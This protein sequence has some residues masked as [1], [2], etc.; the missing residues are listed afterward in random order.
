MKIS[1]L[2][3][4]LL[5]LAYGG[6]ATLAQEAAPPA[7]P[8][9]AA[10]APVPAP[11][12]V[13]IK[14]S[15]VGVIGK[16]DIRLTGPD[17]RQQIV[18]MASQGEGT[19]WDATREA[20]Y[21][22]VPTGVAAVDSH[23]FLSPVANGSTTLTAKVGAF[24]A[25]IPIVVEKF[26]ASQ[27]VS[28]HNEVIPV[29]TRNG[30]NSGGCHGKSGGQNGFRL[31][32]FG[33]E[34]WKDYDWLVHED[35]GRR[36]FP[37]APEHSLLLTKASGEV[38]HQ[39]GARLAIGGGDYG[40]LARWIRQGSP[41]GD[42]EKPK[43]ERIE[44]YPRE[45][46]SKAHASQQLVVTA[47]FNDGSSRDITH[48]AQFEANQK[49]MAESS[50]EG[51]VQLK[52]LTGTTSVMVKFKEHVDVF[53]ATI[54]LGAGTPQLPLAKNQVDEQVFAKLKLLGL[55]PSPV[56][57]DATFLRRVTV[58]ITG[59]LP[60]REESEAFLSLNT[61]D[62]RAKVVDALLDSDDYADYFGQKWTN[63]LRN[64]RSKDEYARG[65]F[66]FHE[67]VR[68]SMKENKPYNQFVS[69]I[70]TA[71]GEIGRNP[72]VAWYRSVSDQKEQMQD[73]AQVFLGIRM[74]CAQCHHH[75]YEKWSQDDY[76]SFTAF[77]S[78]IGRKPGDQPGEEIIFHKRV[79]ASM[80]NPNT[81][82]SLKPAPLGTPAVDIPVE[83]DP[84]IELAK[85]MTDQ[86]NPFFARMV[87]NRYWKHFFGRGLVEPEDDMRVTNP[88]TH[89]ELLDGLAKEFATNGFDLKG[90]IRTLCNSQTYQFSAI[91]ND[92]NAAD[93]QNFSRYYPKRLQAEVLLDAINAVSESKEAFTGQATGTRAVQLPDDKFN[94]QSYF[95]TVFG[96]P[97]MDSACECER[98][99]D[100]N[101]AQ[102]LHL[103]NSDSIQSKLS[104]GQGRAALLAKAS[105]RSDDERLTE[106]YLE[107]LSRKPR[108]EEIAAAKAHLTKKRTV[109]EKEPD[110]AKKGVIEQEAF[111]DILWALLNTKEFLFN[112]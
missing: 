20:T 23:G 88:A 9:Q 106:L 80:Q 55:P 74:Q 45:I 18:V 68:A 13:P 71:S 66:A 24:A 99:A 12:P 112:H 100:A 69:E 15:I 91:P 28:F 17:D 40:V 58:D 62:K 75:P 77:F 101:L 7:A 56:C 72:A 110:V 78:T 67:W 14:L 60:T 73:I 93:Q 29:L 32:L 94:S 87:V 102:S 35:R 107:A 82:V 57:D 3:I 64:K 19:L 51:L 85:W 2:P 43:V 21:S 54:P 61:P 79:P 50:E 1:P 96:R 26:D 16:T 5:T 105:D 46:V 25:T 63:I 36:L 86:Q 108:A 103:I 59:R 92:H 10:V 38:P 98:V 48:I 90:L 76:Y 31:S 47:F 53:R 41:L 97:E 30:C 27:I 81:S 52:D 83:E 44:V 8:P 49:E 42:G 104:N 95:L 11:A 33:Y 4:V 37:A 109:A 34:P 89:P 65:T 111:E 84:R 22:F 39:G 70:L 6:L